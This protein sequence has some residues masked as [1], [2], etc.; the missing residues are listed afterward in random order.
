MVCK[1]FYLIPVI[2]LVFISGIYAQKKDRSIRFPD[3]NGYKTLKCD[4]HIHTV[5]SDG[6]VWPTIRVD[7]AIKDG[8]DAISLT[9]HIEY[10]PK[11]ED[12]PHP[13]RNRSYHLAKEHAKPYDLLIIH[14]AEITRRM[15]PGH[16][17]ALFLT[18]VN[19]LTGKDSISMYK[20]AKKQGAFVFW[21]H[22]NWVAQRKDGIATLTETHRMLIKEN[23]LHGIEVVNDI[24]YSE[25]ALR[26]A[27]EN[28]LTV[29]GT[30]DIHGLVDYQF[31]LA[32]GGHR[33]ISLVFAK[34]KTEASI[35]EALFA[36][37]TV[38]WYNQLLVGNADM[39]KL[40]I[41]A[42]LVFK[43]KGYIGDSQILEVEI[44]N[45]SDAKFILQNKSVYNFYKHHDIIE[46][47]P[48]HSVKLE[49]QTVKGN[50]QTQPLELEVT[51]AV[52]GYKKNYTLKFW[53]N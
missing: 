10:Q 28:K 13:N 5:F 34:E 33:P 47:E 1:N 16:A 38:A 17:N 49:V 25:D 32:G 41:D 12:I 40:L 30:S 18:D 15:P 4:F 51:N 11:K 46:V 50:I 29:M 23:L 20:E 44:L 8:L 31:N 27:Q 3:V 22:P 35:K 21:N 7:E 48:H 24:T 43:N 42:S 36:G 2:L 37:R 53:M 6:M 26:I 39:M 45:T 9:E 19:Q 52:I 14:G